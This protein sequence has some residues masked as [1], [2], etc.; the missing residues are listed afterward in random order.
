MMS[1]FTLVLVDIVFVS[2]ASFCEVELPGHLLRCLCGFPSSNM[3]GFLA[4][5][6]AILSS[7][8]CFNLKASSAEALVVICTS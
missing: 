5:L 1:A 2:A 7:I 8:S 4:L 3:R 6:L